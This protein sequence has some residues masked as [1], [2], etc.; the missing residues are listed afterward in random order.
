LS[1]LNAIEAAKIKRN[2]F[3][4]DVY[5]LKDDHGEFYSILSI[6]VEVMLRSQIDQTKYFT[7]WNLKI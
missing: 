6:S 5:V 4:M 1:L 2:A 3:E 7:A